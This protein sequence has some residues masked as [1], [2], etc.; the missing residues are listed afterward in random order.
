MIKSTADDRQSSTIASPGKWFT[1]A[2]YLWF[3]CAVIVALVLLGALP[4][5]Y[6]HYVQAIRSDPYSLS[7]FNLPFQVLVGLSD[8]ASGFI[9]LGLAG[10]L[11][12]RKPNDRMALFASFFLLI[13]A[14]PSGISLDYFLTTYF[15]A[16]SVYLLA[17]GL[18]TP[19]WVLIMCIFPDGRFVPRWTRWL[20]LV[21]IFLSFPIPTG[22]WS[23]IS[24]GAII[25]VFMLLAYAQVYRYR[26]VSNY[27]ERKQTKWVVFGF[28]VSI[29]L[30]VIASLIYRQPSPPLLNVLPLS[31]T[32]A[33]LRSHLWDIDLIIRRTLV[34]SVL[35]ALLALIYFGGVVLLQQLTRSI[36]ETSDL[37]IVVSTLVIAALFF[38]LRR[39]VQNVID[40]RFYRRKY[41][42]AKTL[43]GFSAT[44]RD[45]V[46]LERLTA[47][48]LNVVNDTLQPAS[49]SLWLKIRHVS[50]LSEKDKGANR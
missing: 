3:V 49:V 37:A 21:S 38:P 30:S 41:D 25:P 17:Q 10:L 13:T 15:G 22:E 16:P 19:L 4:G 5:Y 35:T 44:V 45:E 14:P 28:G 50:A 27:A 1:I 2:H 23:A 29:V 43:A 9:S 24:S 8:L 31:L 33:I 36:A 26:R 48:L 11:F 40:K 34:Y 20:F 18:Q 46:E 7:Q 42:A 12:W 39:R 32:I 47:E 6:S